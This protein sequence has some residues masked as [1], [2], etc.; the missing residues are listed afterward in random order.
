MQWLR[1]GKEEDPTEFWRQTAARRG[2]EIGFF[3]FA[4]LLGKSGGTVLNFPGLLYTVGGVIWF[5]DFERDNWLSRILSS[6]QKYEKTEV[7]FSLSEVKLTRIV[8]RVAAARCI[9]GVIAPEDLAPAS[10]FT[11]VFS[12]PVAQIGLHDG[13]SIFLEVMQR[14]E[15]FAL[16]AQK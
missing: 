5:E 8:S 7:S 2:G 15:L 4:T 16:L 1:R 12:T 11:R 10:F 14:K 9:G 3:T 13:T 6:R